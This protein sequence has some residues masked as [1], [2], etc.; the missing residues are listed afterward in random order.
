MPGGGRSSERAAEP[1]GGQHLPESPEGG[2][3]DAPAAIPQLKIFFA[4]LGDLQGVLEITVDGKAVTAETAVGG[5]ALTLTAPIFEGAETITVK[6]AE[7]NFCQDPLFGS[8]GLPAF[9]FTL[10]L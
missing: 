6:F 3:Q 1:S 10:E 4:A 2:R 5:D 7:Q 9:P 8:T